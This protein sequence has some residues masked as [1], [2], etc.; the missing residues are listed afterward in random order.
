MRELPTLELVGRLVE[1]ATGEKY[2]DGMTVTDV[3]VG[4][5]E[6]G[7][8]SDEAV[9]VFGDWNDKRP[10]FGW[11]VKDQ[12]GDRFPRTSVP[13]VT[14]AD[15]M[16]SRLARVLEA[17][18]AQVEWSDEWVRCG[19]CYRAFRTQPDSYSWTM[20]GAYS[21]DGC[22]YYCA[23]CLKKDPESMLEDYINEPTKCVTFLSGPELVA[24]GFEQE[25]GIYESGWHE[26]QDDDPRKIYDRIL[27]FA[28]E[29][30]EVVFILA[31]QSQFYIR[32]AAYVR[33]P[34]AD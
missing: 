30:V 2:G 22:D 1:I 16:P 17:A 11:N 8:G 9:I 33:T 3:C 13:P 26:G 23:D 12:S 31:E 28:D 18:G 4:Y 27:K 24:L 25:N 34:A 15:T 20:Y 5:A 10:A 6:P 14:K 29:D 7:Y 32:F 19:D 21:E